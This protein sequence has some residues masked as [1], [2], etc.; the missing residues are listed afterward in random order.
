MQINS[1]EPSVSIHYFF[2]L[3]FFFSFSSS[4]F[5]TDNGECHLFFVFFFFCFC[6]FGHLLCTRTSSFRVPQAEINL[7][8]NAENLHEHFTAA[9]AVADKIRYRSRNARNE[10]NEQRQPLSQ[11]PIW[12]K[13]EVVFFRV[14]RIYIGGD[15][16][17]VM[18]DK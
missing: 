17:A 10:L 6:C 15:S 16:L 8:Y 1:R 2:L 3:V 5:S 12:S 18:D 7:I 14:V 4:S 13:S 11:S 9:I